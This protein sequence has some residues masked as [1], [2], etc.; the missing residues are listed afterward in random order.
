MNA[1]LDEGATDG[2]YKKIRPNVECSVN[3]E[4]NPNLTYDVRE[5][6]NLPYYGVGMA[7]DMMVPGRQKRTTTPDFYMNKLDTKEERDTLGQTW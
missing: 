7:R 5:D 3:N 6:L 4:P 2:K 1:A